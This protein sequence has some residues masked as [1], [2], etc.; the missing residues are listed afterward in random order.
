MKLEVDCGIGSNVGPSASLGVSS[1]S[2]T[3]DA[4]LRA[5]FRAATPSARIDGT[6]WYDMARAHAHA[7]GLALG[8]P[9]EVGAAIIAAFS[10]LTGWDLNLRHADTFVRTGRAPTFG[11]HN[12]MASLALVDGADAITG[13]KIGPFC[14]A[15]MGDLSQVVVDSWMNFAADYGPDTAE[16]AEAARVHRVSA[17]VSN[18]GVRRR[19]AIDASIRAIAA[20]TGLMPA[21]VQAIVWIN[22][23]GAAD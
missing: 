21:Q 22:A 23:R 4:N 10:P 9:M 20:E 19:R 3:I 5:H 18:L 16:A 17:E 13:P 6:V 1:M 11:A 2:A 8:K 7:I 15:I 12:R 14:R